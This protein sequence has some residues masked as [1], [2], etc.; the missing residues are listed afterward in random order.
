MLSRPSLFLG[1]APNAQEDPEL[2]RQIL[3]DLFGSR[4]PS[5]LRSSLDR[6]I[7]RLPSGSLVLHLG[8]MVGR[9]GSARVHALLPSAAAAE[10]VDDIA[11]DG[12]AGRVDRILDRYGDEE[13]A[14]MLQFEINAD[15]PIGAVGVE[16]PDRSDD[17]A[18]LASLLERFVEDALCESDRADAVAAWTSE[19][20]SRREV[21]GW[22]CWIAQDVSHLKVTVRENGPL[23]AKAYL[24]VTPT[25]PLFR[26]EVTGR[27]S[28][29][30]TRSSTGQV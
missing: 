4:A 11:V 20:R 21:S 18:R 1:L 14:A 7:E 9:T 16:F 23:A 17:G 3:V 30:D 5:R 15:V 29:V 2:A 6:A 12:L 8:L 19:Y 13:P 28:R 26:P 27:R 24:T 10:Y 22:P 25:F